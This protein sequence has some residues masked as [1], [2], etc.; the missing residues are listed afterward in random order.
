MSFLVLAEYLRFTKNL[1]YN[2]PGKVL[3]AQPVVHTIQNGIISAIMDLNYG[4]VKLAPYLNINTF[5]LAVLASYK[6]LQ[7]T[8]SESALRTFL[9]TFKAHADKVMAKITV[10]KCGT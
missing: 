9:S 4:N 6:E 5:F 7:T 3:S 1:L 2:K 10:Q 8:A